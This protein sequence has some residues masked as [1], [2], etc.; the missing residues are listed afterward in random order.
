VLDG[1]FV[2]RVRAGVLVG[3]QELQLLPRSEPHESALALADGAIAG[4][5]TRECAFNLERN[6]PAVAAS[7]VEQVLSPKKASSTQAVEPAARK[8]G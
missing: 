6:V 2:E 3:R 5:G 4:R 7:L 8:R 1:V